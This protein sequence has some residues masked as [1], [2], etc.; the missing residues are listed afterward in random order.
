[1]TSK[2][3]LEILVDKTGIMNVT[4]ARL[5]KCLKCGKCQI[6][7]EP[8]ETCDD[9]NLVMTIKKDLDR[10][11][12]LEKENQELRKAIKQWNING[13]NLLKENTKLKKAIEIL[14]DKL[15]IK[16]EVYHNG[17]CTLNHKIISNCIVSHE[18]CLRHLEVEEYKLLKEVLEND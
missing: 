13:G 10:L 3:C 11:E 6:D 2:E 5:D 17:G 8:V 7:D 9:Y 15:D 16:L 1:M 12:K 18:R 14:N 4:C